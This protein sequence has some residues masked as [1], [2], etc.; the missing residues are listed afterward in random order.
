MSESPIYKVVLVGDGNVGKTSLVRRFCE[1]KFEDSRILT[2]GVDFQ[3]KAV[4]LGE[5]EVRLS[6]WD[7]AGQDRF[8]TFRD[9]FYSGT[10]AVALVYDVTAPATF[11]NLPR[12]R[13]EVMASAPGAPMVV[14]CNKLDLGPVVPPGEVEGW[15]KFEGRMPFLQTSA[16]TGENIEQFFQGLAY[17]AYKHKEALVEIEKMRAQYLP[18]SGPP[19][20]LPSGS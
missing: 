8:R 18:P 2:I 16:L 20:G 12:W 4:Q 10:L 13:E 5:R 3:I 9:Q 1:G 6:I 7:V 11:F 14:I 17:L 15:A 19:S